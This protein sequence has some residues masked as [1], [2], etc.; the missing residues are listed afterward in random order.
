[1]KGYKRINRDDLSLRPFY[2]FQKG[3][4]FLSAGEENGCNAMTVAWG[5]LGTLF[6]LPVATVFARPQRYT[7]EFLDRS[8]WFTLSFPGEEEK[9]AL[10]YMGTHSGR[11]EDKIAAAGLTKGF[12]NAGHTLYIR[13][14]ELVLV[15]RKIYQ[16][17]L[18][19]SGF[20]D[21]E[22]IRKN[23]PL[24]D[25]HFVYI[26]KVEEIYARMKT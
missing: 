23:Y 7:R 16:G 18:K 3:L 22:V 8:G 11:E 21:P 12:D 17:I 6:N 13:E 2:C 15:C 14:S 20:T 19:E 26:G 24:K 10:N 9:N 25:F 4:A 5:E 1:M